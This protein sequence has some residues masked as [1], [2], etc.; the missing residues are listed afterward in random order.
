MVNRISVNLVRTSNP[1]SFRVHRYPVLTHCTATAFVDAAK[2]PIR[3]RTLISQD[4]P[5]YAGL[6]ES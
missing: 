4:F 1:V 3:G 5:Q 6:V 2:P